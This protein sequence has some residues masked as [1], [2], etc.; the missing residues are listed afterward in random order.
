MRSEMSDYAR[1][2][3]KNEARGVVR[4]DLTTETELSL[5][6]KEAHDIDVSGPASIKSD[7]T[8]PEC[9]ELYLL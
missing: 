4:P 3:S 7:S 8:G 6:E 1:E 5:A 2:Q 9:S